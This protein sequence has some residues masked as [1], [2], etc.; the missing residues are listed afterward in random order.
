MDNLIEMVRT[1]ERKTCRTTPPQIEEL[2]EY[3]GFRLCRL[4]QENPGADRIGFRMEDATGNVCF[5]TPAQILCLAMA[6]DG[7]FLDGENA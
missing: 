5:A 1:A 2:M 4:R 7:Y 6:I 3:N